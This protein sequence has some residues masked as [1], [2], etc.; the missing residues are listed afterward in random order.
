MKNGNETFL[1]A[2]TVSKLKYKKPFCHQSAFT[3]T[4]VHN[5]YLFDCNYKIQ[6]DYDMF[7]RAYLNKI[8]FSKWDRTISKFNMDGMSSNPH[9]YS[10]VFNE[11]ISLHKKN[12]I[13]CLN[14][15]IIGL[16]YLK[17]WIHKMRIKNNI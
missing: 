14:T 6:A 7:L 13:N 10:V 12:R 11:L 1:K 8:S 9:N 2:G 15:P 17:C 5:T 16:Y 4:S 3:R